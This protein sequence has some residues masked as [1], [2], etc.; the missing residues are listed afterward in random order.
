MWVK[1]FCWPSEKQLDIVNCN[2]QSTSSAPQKSKRDL[3]KSKS[4]SKFLYKVPRLFFIKNV[5][6]KVIRG[7]S[8]ICKNIDLLLAYPS[9]RRAEVGLNLRQVHHG[10]TFISYLERSNK[11]NLNES[12]RA[13][14]SVGNI[15]WNQEPQQPLLILPVCVRASLC[16]MPDVFL[17]ISKTK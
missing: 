2:F 4:E 9:C 5:Q 17:W 10:A 12:N 7:W 13:W 16:L 11:E 14:H 15:M 3:S 8:L 1:L 6:I